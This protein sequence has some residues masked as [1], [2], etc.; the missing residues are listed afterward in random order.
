MILVFLRVTLPLAAADGP[1]FS[2]LFDVKAGGGMTNTDEALSGFD[3]YANLRLQERV[4]NTITFYTAFNV[5][6]ASGMFSSGT[7]AALFEAE[8][9]YLRWAEDLWGLD[10]GLMPLHFGYGQVFAPSDFLIKKNPAVLDARPRGITGAALYQYPLDNVKITEFAVFPPGMLN[11]GW[12][13]HHFGAT[14]EAH[15]TT[16]SFQALYAFQTPSRR[17]DQYEKGV[18][19]FGGSVKLEAE[20][21]LLADGLYRYDPTGNFDHEG[22]ALSAGADYTFGKL[23]VLAEYLY[24]GRNSATHRTMDGLFT[25]RNMLGTTF[26]YAVS[27]LTNITLHGLWSVSD[28]SLL[29]SFVF[30]HDLMQGLTLTVSAQIPLDFA[31]DT[32]GELGPERL[33]QR[34]SLTAGL[35]LRI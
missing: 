8:R 21:G 13:D 32:P 4:K 15:F 9:L 16:A 1:S 33:G 19:F 3:V 11:N 6:A 12:Q 23:Y 30:S 28:R 17:P 24:N 20:I 34:F 35:R 27:D 22:L 10:A 7:E 5:Q 31:D 26:L 14:L 25:A 2:G 18:H 29:P